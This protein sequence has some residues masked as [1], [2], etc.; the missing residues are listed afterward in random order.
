MKPSIAVGTK[1]NAKFRSERSRE[2]LEQLAPIFTSVMYVLI[3]R[4][5]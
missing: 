3:E 5:K 4:E 2:Q 1:T